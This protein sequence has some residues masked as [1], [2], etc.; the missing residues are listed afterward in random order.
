ML[1]A[2]AEGKAIKAKL[3]LFGAALGNLVEAE[4]KR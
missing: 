4:R 1:S 3:V 2:A